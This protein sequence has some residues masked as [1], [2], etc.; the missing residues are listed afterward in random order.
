M[1]EA[2]LV[3]SAGAFAWLVAYVAGAA[4][5]KVL[6]QSGHVASVVAGHTTW[7]L[8][9]QVV[10]LAL[11]AHKPG[12]VCT[13]LGLSSPMVLISIAQS[14]GQDCERTFAAPGVQI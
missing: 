7:G 4:L 3:G 2:V 8:S 13:T 6:W 1:Q 11:L 10:P 9:H 5:H 14:G 12:H